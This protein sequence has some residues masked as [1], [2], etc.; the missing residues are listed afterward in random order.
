VIVDVSTEYVELVDRVLAGEDEE[1]E[2]QLLRAGGYAMPAIMAKFP[3]PFTVDQE[4]LD[5]DPLPRVGECGPVLRLI[6]SQRRTALPFVL[7]HVEAPDSDSRFWA[8]YLLTE[9]VYPDAIDAAVARAFDDDAKVRRAAR[10]AVHALA[11]AH[12]IPV[13]ERLGEFTLAQT[14]DLRIRAIEALAETREP[15]AV[16]V[17]LPLLEENQAEVAASTQKALMTLTRQD[18]GVDTEKWTTWWDANK[19]RHRLEWLIDTLMHEHRKMRGLAGE[20]LKW[21]TK[22]SFGY[23]D[24]LPRRERER[25][26][27]KFRDWWENIGRV[28]FSRAATRGA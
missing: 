14:I 8:T 2:T 13:V 25:S 24:D 5:A 21:I 15:T 26:Q 1:A 27:A 20:E 7:A 4:R 17:L 16:P 3:G 19:N 11:E 12:P 9:L 22:E 23:Y 18:F 10:A 28:R 6:A